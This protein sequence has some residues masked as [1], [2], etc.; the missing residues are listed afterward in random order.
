MR[1]K[2]LTSEGV[3]EL[4][5]SD[6]NPLLLYMMSRSIWQ[7]FFYYTPNWPLLFFLGFFIRTVHFPVAGFVSIHRSIVKRH[8]AVLANLL[9]LWQEPVCFF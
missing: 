9:S 7:L 3:G 5:I 6:L 1:Q 2:W 8:S 4:S